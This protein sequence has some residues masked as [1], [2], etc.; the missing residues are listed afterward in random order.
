M[1]NMLTLIISDQLGIGQL[2]VQDNSNGKCN[3]EMVFA[4]AS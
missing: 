2:A 1:Q 4:V 3:L